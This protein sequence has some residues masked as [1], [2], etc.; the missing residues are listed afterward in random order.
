MDLALHQLAFDD[1]LRGDA[2]VIHAGLPE[3][4][5]AAHALEADENVLQRVV[6][7]MAHMQGAG[8]IG[9]R[10]DDGE[11]LGVRLGAGAR[12]KRV[13]VLPD[14]GDL[15]LDRPGIV[16]LLKHGGPHHPRSVG[17]L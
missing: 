2:G 13:G 8:D 3:H 1:H 12:P 15:R 6:Q 14:S 5:P 17:P 7:R 4:V 10:N 11:G 16:I 9:R